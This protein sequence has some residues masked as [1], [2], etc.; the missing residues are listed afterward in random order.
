MSEQLPIA[1]FGPDARDAFRFTW[2]NTREGAD[3]WV[4]HR[5]RW[6]AGTVIGRGRK[7]VLVS[8]EV[9]NWKRLLISKPYSDLRRRKDSRR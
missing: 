3:V 9:A 8:I 4:K 2:W 5:S 7:R 1:D 6:C